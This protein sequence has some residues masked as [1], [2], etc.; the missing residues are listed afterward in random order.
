MSTSTD[1]SGIVDTNRIDLVLQTRCITETNRIDLV[2]LGMQNR[3]LGP[4]FWQPLT[5]RVFISAMQVPPAVRV[6]Q[7]RFLHCGAPG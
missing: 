4:N 3:A 5:G 6:L 7:H 2:L 1:S